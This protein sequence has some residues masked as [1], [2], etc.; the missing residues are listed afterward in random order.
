M[1]AKRGKSGIEKL[2]MQR[3]SVNEMNVGTSVN[4]HQ[5]HTAAVSFVL[6]ISQLKIKTSSVFW[7][8]RRG[9]AVMEMFGSL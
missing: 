4:R 3:P 8:V 1:S 9:R 2:K 6:G 7:S 5:L